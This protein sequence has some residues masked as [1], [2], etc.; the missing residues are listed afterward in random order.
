MTHRVPDWPFEQERFGEKVGVGDGRCT[1]LCESNGEQLP[2]VVPLV[3][4]L[5]D[6]QPLVTLKPDER[7]VEGSRQRL[8]CGG[9]AD[10]RLTLEEQ[11]SAKSDREVERG[12][13]AFVDQVIH[14]VEAA[15]YLGGIMECGDYEDT[16]FDASNAS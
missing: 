13:Q 11:W 12:G 3:K 10:P 8:G 16:P 14:L 5:A 1:R 9:L 4:C 2:L 15:L 7:D 6:R